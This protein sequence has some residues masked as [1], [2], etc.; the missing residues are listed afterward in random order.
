[1][2][3]TIKV[4]AEYSDKEGTKVILKFIEEAKKLVNENVLLPDSESYPLEVVEYDLSEDEPLIYGI[5]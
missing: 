4:K 3:P 1:M 2:E 5:C